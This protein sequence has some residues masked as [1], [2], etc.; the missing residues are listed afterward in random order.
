MDTFSRIMDRYALVHRPYPNVTPKFSHVIDY[1]HL[2]RLLTWLIDSKA[3]KWCHTQRFSV[4][5]IR[6]GD[7]MA[8]VK[9]LVDY[10]FTWDACDL[11]QENR[12]DGDAQGTDGACDAWLENSARLLKYARTV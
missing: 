3:G 10:S 6:T 2:R 9:G 7:G 4:Y 11:F 12:W 8:W 5:L 1:F